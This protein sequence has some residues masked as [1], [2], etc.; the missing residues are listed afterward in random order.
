MAAK[1]GYPDAANI[2]QNAG[3]DVTKPPAG[4]L[5]LTWMPIKFRHRCVSTPHGLYFGSGRRY[6]P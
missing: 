5:V 6:A 3:E 2:A 1:E 4:G